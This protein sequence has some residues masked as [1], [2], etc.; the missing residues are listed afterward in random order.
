MNDL[1]L[2]THDDS[3]EQQPLEN[4]FRAKG[5]KTKNEMA[6]DVSTS[7]QY[8]PYGT[9]A[10]NSQEQFLQP[11]SKT[12]TWPLVTMEVS[13]IAVVLTRTTRALMKIFRPSLN[14]KLEKNSIPTTTVAPATAMLRWKMQTAMQ[15]TMRTDRRKNRRPRTERERLRQPPQERGPGSCGRPQRR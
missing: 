7:H 14:L 2:L 5:I 9:N 15:G 3:E 12:T 6:D 4:F 13:R 1:E 10:V 8:P 11:H